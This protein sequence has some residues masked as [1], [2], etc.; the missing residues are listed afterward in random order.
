MWS[1][2]AN[3][4]KGVCLCFKSKIIKGFPYLTI[5]SKAV[6][7]NH[8]DYDIIPPPINFLNQNEEPGRFF[9]LL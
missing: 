1:H 5:N 9:I 6:R 2:Y 3:H 8:M 7:L 4:H